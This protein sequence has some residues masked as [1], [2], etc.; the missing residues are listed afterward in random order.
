[1]SNK[2]FIL[3]IITAI[4]CLTM[5]PT[6]YASFNKSLALS[7]EQAVELAIK[8]NNE[9]KELE[10]DIA[11]AEEQL[12]EAEA[13]FYPNI[14]LNSNYSKSGG[15]SGSSLYSLTL[16]FQ[17][18][19]Y[20]GGLLKNSYETAKK[21]IEIAKLELKL[22]KKEVRA[23]VVAEYYDILKAKKMVSFYNKTVTKN[24]DYLRIAQ[25]N[26]E[27]G[28]STN[29]DV[30]K[31]KVSL[32]QAKQ[33]LLEAE[34]SLE[35]NKLTL[36][37]TLGLASNS[38]L[39]LSEELNWKREEINFE[40]VMEYAFLYR[41]DIKVLDLEE[42]VA[43]INL[44]NARANKSPSLNLS[45]GYDAS[46]D[47]L[48]ISDGV[49]SAALT[50]SYNLFD[51][52]A[53]NSKVEQARKELEKYKVQR[54]ELENN[55]ELEIRT[56]ILNLSESE[57]SIKLMGLTLKEA[58]DNLSQTELKYQKGIVTSYDVLGAQTTYQE[59]QTDY[60]EAIYNY[61]VTLAYLDQA[62]GKEI[63]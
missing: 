32:N 9:I 50:L 40:E 20:Q 12:K 39:E 33:D 30:L 16:E 17:Q 61:N 10:K 18:S 46:D 44:D 34:H 36:K 38:G 14:D 56:Q 41:A 48:K 13:D 7:Q 55:I 4:F 57:E 23:E 29:T 15:D 28:I 42:E 11:I 62:M 1:M 37:N 51:G 24:Q 5:I 47:K 35:L 26:R 3:V 58:E 2:K 54:D 43:T 45:G 31:A 53:N 6:A 60:Y 22:K 52:G 19:L 59:V 25:A 27:V 63:N 21:N 8:Q 49:W